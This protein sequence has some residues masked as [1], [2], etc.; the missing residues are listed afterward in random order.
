[1]T[2]R[3]TDQHYSLEELKVMVEEGKYAGIPVCAHCESLE[4][5]KAAIKAGVAS[6]EHGE[7]LDA[8]C[9][10]LMK[11]NDVTMVPTFGLFVEWFSEYVPPERPEHEWLPG[12]TLGEKEVNRIALNFRTA[13]EA[14]IRIAVGADSFCGSL[15]PYGAYT[16]KEV[17]ALVD[18]GM[19][20]MEA[21]VAATK[22]GAELLRID[23]ITGTIEEGKLADLLILDADPVAEIRNL[24]LD[25]IYQVIKEGRVVSK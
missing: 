9:L 20:T 19:S 4:S 14:G 13:A 16:H 15:T 10:E 18:G 23:D 2:E 7:D 25:N 8:E 5:A 11:A 1:M 21:I 24:C 3:E 6:I 22:S 12:D 17:H